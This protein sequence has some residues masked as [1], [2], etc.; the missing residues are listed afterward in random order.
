MMKLLFLFLIVLIGQ[1]GFTQNNYRL[2]IEKNGKQQFLDI[3]QTV[4]LEYTQPG[5]VSLKG[6]LVELRD[7]SLIIKTFGRHTELK[8]IQLSS[9]TGIKRSYRSL[10]AIFGPLAIASVAGAAVLMATNRNRSG[11]FL[12]SSY[13]PGNGGNAKALLTSSLTLP[14]LILTVKEADLYTHTNGYTFMIVRSK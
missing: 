7:S 3:N 1:N 11:I 8:E 14:Y 13:D 9:L 6:R 5:L 2:L 4:R 10:K 12:T